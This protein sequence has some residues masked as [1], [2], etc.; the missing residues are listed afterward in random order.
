MSMCNV[1][2]S[3]KKKNWH[4]AIWKPQDAV[5]GNISNTVPELVVVLQLQLGS[6]AGSWFEFEWSAELESAWP[7]IS[8]VAKL[9]ILITSQGTVQWFLLVRLWVRICSCDSSAGLDDMWRCKWW[10]QV[11]LFFSRPRFSLTYSAL[12]STTSSVR[13]SMLYCIFSSTVY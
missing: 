3:S 4:V 12:L 2:Q 8:F 6:D 9:I 5:P 13:Q 1:L 11:E 10:K 7:R